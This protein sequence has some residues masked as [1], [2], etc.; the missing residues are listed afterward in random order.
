MKVLLAF[1]IITIS[2]SPAFGMSKEPKDVTIPDFTIQ[3]A[4]PERAIYAI[5]QYFLDHKVHILEQCVFSSDTYGI[6]IVTGG[7]EAL[8]IIRVVEE[9]L[10]SENTYHY[11]DAGLYS[12]LNTV[13]RGPQKMEKP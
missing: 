13:M 1:L 3:I 11:G 10:S 8:L 6:R 9:G 7:G 5:V 2:I 12:E 4:D